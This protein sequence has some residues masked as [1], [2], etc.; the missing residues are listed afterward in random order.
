MII[1]DDANGADTGGCQIQQHR[2][3][4]AA[5]TNNQD[6]GLQQ[7]FLSGVTDFIKNQ[8]AGIALKLGVGQLHHE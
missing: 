3:P 8:M 2:C 1:I 7:F 6:P 5:G 4:K